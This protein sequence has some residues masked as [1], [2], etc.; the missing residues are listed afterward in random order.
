MDMHTIF[1]AA[2]G[3][4]RRAA[5]A[6]LKS[7]LSPGKVIL[8]LLVKR[9]AILL[10]PYL[11][12]LV[13]IFFMFFFVYGIL[14]LIPRYIVEDVKSY[15]GSLT[16]KVVAIFSTGRRD[17]WTLG[18]D[19]KLYEKYIELD[20]KWLNKFMDQETL[21]SSMVS[22]REGNAAEEDVTVK[23]VWGRFYDSDSG[24]P[25][26]RPQVKQ[27]SVSWALL[28]A[29]DRVLGDPVITGLPERR[30]DPG[31]HFKRL[32]PVLKWQTFELYYH[33]SW[34]ERTG[35]G[36]NRSSV[37]Y[38]KTYRHSIRLLAE[39]QSYEADKMVYNWESKRYHHR[40]PHSDFVE[41]A[42]YP[43]LANSRSRGPY[44]QKLKD[45]LSG[46]GLSKASNLELVL[47]LAMNYDDEFKYNTGIIS[48]NLAEL[49][50][51]TEGATHFPSGNAGGFQWPAGKYMTVTSGYGWRTHPVLGGLRFHKGV[52][53]AMPR[54]TPVLSAWPGR[55]ILAGWV[56]GYGQTVIIDHGKYR[57]LYAHLLSCSVDPGREVGMGE[58]IGKADSTGMS[59]GDHLHFEIRSG[60]GHT[61]YHDPVALFNSA[62]AGEGVIK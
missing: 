32:E 48:G 24:I 55:V 30:P 59:T 54:G 42:V 15:G 18:D 58:E 56:T 46:R 21:D 60:A 50:V 35:S 16:D 27:H 20:R 26:E 17:S 31:G 14:F 22:H 49:L 33:C 38:T 4:L 2:K 61:E 8:A 9:L 5:G 29:V 12:P 57:T 62:S 39:V 23:K 13:A 6:A 45:L 41:E 19:R 7:A 34:T 28:A 52:D 3:S 10:V 40:D 36:E 11:V 1:S 37:R 53:I 51:D 43:A 44:F 25:A 47:N